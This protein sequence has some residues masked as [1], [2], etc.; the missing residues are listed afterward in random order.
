MASSSTATAGREAHHTPADGVA[1]FE[2]TRPAYVAKSF[3]R[4]STL[5]RLAVSYYSR[6]GAHAQRLHSSSYGSKNGA[7]I[8]H[9]YDATGIIDDS[10]DEARAKAEGDTPIFRAFVESFVNG[11]P[12]NHL[13]FPDYNLK[14][15]W[16]NLAQLEDH[17][18]SVFQVV[19]G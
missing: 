3:D 18:S 11:K 17:T 10:E 2:K 14:K 16:H 15:H 9:P 6:P 4:H 7:G 13:T 8:Y 19:R 5:L 1:V 12:S